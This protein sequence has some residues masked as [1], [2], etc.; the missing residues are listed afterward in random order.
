MFGTIIWWLN[1]R[2][3]D[4][5]MRPI[6]FLGMSLKVLCGLGVGILYTYYYSSGDTW[7]YF[8]EAT[9]MTR[10]ARSDLFEYW[11]ALIDLQG[12]PVSSI[13]HNQ[14]R[15]LF[16]T[17]ILS[18][19]CLLTNDNYWLASVYFSL[20]SFSGL[21][22]LANVLIKINNNKSAAILAFI[23]FPSILFWS[24]G[25]LKESL[26][27][28]AL[29]FLTA[30]LIQYSYRLRRFTILWAFLD[31]LFIYLLWK[32]KYYYAGIFFLVSIP[33]GLLFI[34][35]HFLP[36]LLNSTAKQAFFFA[37]FGVVAL[38]GISWLHPNFYFS[39]IIEVVVDNH[40]AIVTNS[41][42]HNL[43]HY[44][45]LSKDP[46]AVLINAPLALVSG[47]FRPFIGE[48]TEGFKILIGLENLMILSLLVMALLSVPK[49]V[50]EETK[51]YLLALVVYVV[52]MSVML[53]LSTP[54][55]GTLTRYKVGFLPYF[56]YI[57]SVENRAVKWLNQKLF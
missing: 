51:I 32:I 44:D 49:S 1:Q 43:I 47:L 30:S 7:L 17:K 25:I 45:N 4:H 19:I 57:I 6:M 33:L 24:S 46:I 34:F 5:P 18:L 36:K 41:E 14:P 16:F 35:K 52:I 37:L 20:F 39:R 50:S 31:I 8:S 23:L 26:S 28:G 29:A 15:A 22:T 56:I 21:W 48:S 11:K 54:N 10:L 38:V 27:M 42:S 53:S 3:K 12:E 40:D 55:F 9:K 13:F 2:Y